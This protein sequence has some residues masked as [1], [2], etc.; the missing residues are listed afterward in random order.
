MSGGASL[1]IDAGGI[2]AAGKVHAAIRSW[3]DSP[4]DTAVYTHGHV[5]HVFAVPMFDA[6][7]P[8][9][10]PM[11]WRTRTCHPGSTATG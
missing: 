3:T 10:T 5:D 4:L 1:M 11:L 8:P 2:L 9:C 7:Q 6:E